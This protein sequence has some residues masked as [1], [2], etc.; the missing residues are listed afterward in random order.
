VV[1][2]ERPGAGGNETRISYLSTAIAT[3]RAHL[4]STVA[5]SVVDPGNDSTLDRK[6][7]KA[8]KRDRWPLSCS[9]VTSGPGVVP[10]PI[11]KLVGK[12][13][14][15]GSTETVGRAVYE[16]RVSE[17]F[18]VKSCSVYRHDTPWTGRGAILIPYLGWADVSE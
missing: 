1:A 7:E 2:I 9:V 12:V 15:G 13:Y 11:L 16:G 3:Y 18:M 17:S 10:V 8:P 6:A 4:R 5:G 14:G